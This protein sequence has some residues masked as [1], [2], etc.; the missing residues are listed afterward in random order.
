MKIFK[1]IIEFLNKPFP[2]IENKLVFYRIVLAL[3]LFVT[4]FLYIFQPFGIST[5]ESNKFLICLGFGSMTF[6]GAT[7]YEIVLH[8]I[9]NIRGRQRKWTFSK[10]ILDN[11]GFML[12]I[13][14]ANFLFARFLLFGY[15]EWS[16]FPQMIYSTF[17]IGIIPLVAIGS[18]AL[19]NSERKYQAIASEI[20]KA[21]SNSS[22]IQ[23]TV[24]RLIF[25][26]EIDHIRYIEALQNYAKIGYI[27]SEGQLKEQIERTTLKSILSETEGT[28]I[29]RCHRSY[30]VNKETIT[31]AA[32]NAQG[33]LLSL[34]DCDKVIPVSRTLVPQFR[35]H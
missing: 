8:T 29:I 34:T 1:A 4:F 16:L 17:M 31:T 18:I 6:L 25:D 22:G 15:V 26:I 14:L 27:D 20:N 13:S 30:L 21:K 23:D 10:W 7:V 12:S 32:G 2:E 33:L 19:F 11:L 35:E 24:G 28:P 3:S 5:L 9:F